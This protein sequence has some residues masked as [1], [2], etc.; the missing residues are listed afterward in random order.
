MVIPTTHYQ[1]PLLTTP[2]RA[3]LIVELF[4]LVQTPQKN[5]PLPLPTP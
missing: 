2:V 1:L 5:P 4:V 3:G